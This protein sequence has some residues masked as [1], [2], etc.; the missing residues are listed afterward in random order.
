MSAS[1]KAFLEASRRRVDDA[2]GHVLPSA[3]EPPALLHEAMRYAVLGGG[4]RL[5]PALAFA[6]ARACGADES[7]A[8]PVALAVELVHAY[9]L[10]HD[11]LPAMDD[12]D[13]RRGVPT[14][15]IKFGEDIAILT[16]DALLALAFAVLGRAQ[17]PGSVV[18]QL[19]DAAGS[20]ELVGGQVDDL[21]LDPAALTEASLASIH[22]RKT[23]AL[24]RFCVCAAA[25]LAGAATDTAKRLEQFASAYSAAFQ[26]ADDLQDAERSE[27]SIL[28]VLSPADAGRLGA[29]RAQ[30][31]LRA[32]EPLGPPADALVGL[33]AVV[34]QR[35]GTL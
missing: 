11:D 7:R 14:V 19:A 21:R 29:R 34:S 15:H 2:L 26:I 22:A 16:G 31:A 18:A 32:I 30:E 17:V 9:S 12:D 4:K 25:E 33:V 28:R 1:G 3:S 8:L 13:E 10:V 23:G 20:R 24:F 27:T 5:R 35:L 6:A